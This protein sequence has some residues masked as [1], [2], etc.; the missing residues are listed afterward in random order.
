A[1]KREQIPPW[2]INRN[3]EGPE[4]VRCRLTPRFPA[5]FERSNG[6]RFTVKPGETESREVL[7]V[8]GPPV[9]ED[10]DCDRLAQ[11]ES[12]NAVAAPVHTGGVS[13]TRNVGG[14]FV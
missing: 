1:G 12:S 11:Q 3:F 14:Q 8:I 10:G 6:D 4:I 9:T 13:A 2:A 7:A 5:I